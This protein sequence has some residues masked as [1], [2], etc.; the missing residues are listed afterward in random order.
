MANTGSSG[1]K[2]AARAGSSSET[3]LGMMTARGP[4]AR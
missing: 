1:M 3:W 2:S 4:A